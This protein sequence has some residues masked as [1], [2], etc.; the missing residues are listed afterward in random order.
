MDNKRNKAL[1]TMALWVAT[2]C[3]LLMLSHLWTASGWLSERF[4][5]QGFDYQMVYYL[6][7]AV[8]GCLFMAVLYA[9]RATLYSSVAIIL[10]TI[11]T[12]VA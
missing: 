11:L 12:R 2:L 10:I 8:F 6:R 7:Y 3:T 5:S 9:A 1:E 4:F